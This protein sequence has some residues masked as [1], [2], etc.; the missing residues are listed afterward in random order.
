MREDGRSDPSRDGTRGPTVI[1][2]PARRRSSRSSQRLGS[3]PPAV[4]QMIHR[5]PSRLASA[6]PSSTCAK[7]TPRS[8]SDALEAL[9][10]RVH[11][12]R[13]RAAQPEVVLEAA[14]VRA[15][16]EHRE[17]RGRR[18]AEGVERAVQPALQ[19]GVHDAHRRRSNELVE[20]H[21]VERAEEL[22]SR[23]RR[24]GAGARDDR[25]ARRSSDRAR[26]PCRC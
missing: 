16:P 6:V 26:P 8:E 20:A 1:R 14:L 22:A 23:T 5:A 17:E 4:G 2:A 25:W 19:G 7:G 21:L 3:T 10:E 24:R 12:G 11:L 13:H 9:D 18:R 15:A